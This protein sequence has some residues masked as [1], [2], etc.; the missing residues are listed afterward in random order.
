MKEMKEA[1]FRVIKE[2]RTQGDGVP[3]PFCAD[4]VNRK[5]ENAPDPKNSITFT[6]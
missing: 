5:A 6:P 4:S 1:E 2:K 3:P